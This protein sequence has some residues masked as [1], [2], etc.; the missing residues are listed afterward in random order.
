[1]PR[2]RATA[3]AVECGSICGMNKRKK[4]FYR[5]IQNIFG[6]PEKIMEPTC[7]C[8]QLAK[9]TARVAPACDCF[10]NTQHAR[11]DLADVRWACQSCPFFFFRVSRFFF[12]TKQKKDVSRLLSQ[13][14]RR[15]FLS[16]QRVF[17]VVTY[18][19]VP[20]HCSFDVLLR[21]ARKK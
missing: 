12:G 15:S 20:C 2:S 4:Y 8:H 9:E 11:V 1:M 6:S 17:V 13:L 21:F 19:R 16:F 14:G 5:P 7:S 10:G 3:L 18:T